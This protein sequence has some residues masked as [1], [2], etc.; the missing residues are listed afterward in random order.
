MKPYIIVQTNPKTLIE[1]L[2]YVMY[3]SKSNSIWYDSI[4]S[5]SEFEKKCSDEFEKVLK[6]LVDKAQVFKKVQK[7]CI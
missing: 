4:P 6:S 1:N 2:L 5:D 3:L 7:G